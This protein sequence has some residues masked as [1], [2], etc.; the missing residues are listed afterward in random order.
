MEYIQLVSFVLTT[1]TSISSCISFPVHFRVE[2]ADARSKK[3]R[4]VDMM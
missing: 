3:N 4:N 2:S 1:E